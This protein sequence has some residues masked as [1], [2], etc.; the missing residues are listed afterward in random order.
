MKNIV[1]F[2][3]PGAGKGTQAEIIKNTYNLFH[4]STGD[5]FRHN[6]KNSTSLGLLA[7]EYMDKGE[8]VPDEVTIEMLNKVV[9]SNLDCNGFVFDG[10]PRTTS[11]AMALDKL[12]ESN[13]TNISAMIAFEVEDSILV[14]RLTKRG[15]T[16]G[17]VDDSNES[18]IKNRIK[19]YYKKTA[20]LKQYYQD[21]DRYYGIN[22][23]GQ[24][25]EISVRL[26]EVIDCL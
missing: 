26:K 20:I 19:E 8:L 25:D 22:A 10:F 6:I 13:N 24:I 5:V 7:K 21:Q 23:E 14:S 17:R 1:L 2:G 12:M 16:S 15:E 9:K 3:P 18:I 11:Q 4:I